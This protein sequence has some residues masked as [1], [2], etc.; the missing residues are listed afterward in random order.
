MKRICFPSRKAYPLKLVC[1]KRDKATSTTQQ[2]HQR[3]SLLM[4]FW[5]P[6][7]IEQDTDGTEASYEAM[8]GF[9]GSLLQSTHCRPKWKEHCCK[10]PEMFSIWIIVF[11]GLVDTAV[12]TSRSGYLQRCLIKHLEGLQVGYDL[13]VRDSDSSVVQFYYGEDGLDVMKTSFLS[14]KQFPFM[15]GN[16]QVRRLL[17]CKNS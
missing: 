3:S 17:D 13:T 2:K 9:M 12:K 16:Y 5:G 8:S 10:K 1:W 11:Q 6:A 4:C 14:E 15:A 7:E